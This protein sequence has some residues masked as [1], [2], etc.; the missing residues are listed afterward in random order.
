MKA[1]ISR[2]ALFSSAVLVL[3]LAFVGIPA[4]ALGESTTSANWSGYAVHKSGVTFRKVAA[5]W[6]QP[7]A[8]CTPGYARYSASWVGLGG[9]GANS[10]ALEQIGTEA[11]CGASGA[12]RSSAWYELV[13]A[14]SAKIRMTVKPGDSMN[15]SVTVVGHRV[16][17]DLADRTRHTSFSKTVNDSVIDVTSA[18]WIVEAPSECF[19]NEQCRPL[20][21]A[22]FGTLA[23]TGATATTTSGRSG[24]I[25]S[26]FWNATKITLSP[27][28]RTYVVYGAEA[29]ATPSLLRN[30]GMSF[31]VAYSQATPNPGLPPFSSKIAS[32]ARA[33]SAVQP[34]GT[35]R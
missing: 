34:G 25:S 7:A 28:G 1:P 26:R 23:F 29:E 32:A 33:T 13:P 9:Y 14:P 20:P 12:L 3:A 17:L 31:Q 6:K 4:A 27:S 11:D 35:R 30:A 19:T 21:L 2:F 15:A 5:A 8:I 16:T 10:D 18:E 24:S 22:D